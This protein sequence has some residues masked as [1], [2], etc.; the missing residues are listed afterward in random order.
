MT[1]SE[2]KE[3]Q[4]EFLNRWTIENVK[5]L[6][7]HEYVG[8]GNKDTFCQWVE[9]KTKM[10]GSI[11]GLTSIKFGIYERKDPFKRPKNYKNDDQYSWVQSYGDNRESAFGSTKRDILKI[12]QFSECGKF[13][14]IDNIPLLDLFKWKVAF[15]YSNERLIPIY[16]R[17][18][19]YKIANHFGLVTNRHIKISEIQN[20]MMQ[21]KPTHLSVYAYMWELYEKFGNNKDRK[22]VI[23]TQKLQRR[24]IRKA[25][26]GRNITPQTRT[27]TRSYIADQ[28]HN[29][30]QEALVLLLSQKY[31]RENV[32]LEENYVD[33]KLI[34]PN[35]IAFYEVKTSSYAS[36]CIKEA[37]GQILLYSSNDTDKRSKKH[38]IVGQ[39]PITEND[40]KFID[41]L[42]Q[43]INL[44]IDY[45]SVEIE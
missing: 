22:E 21:N 19:L 1:I 43:N 16:K 25:S 38:I 40:K 10:L 35:F 26:N 41:F 45:L 31:G 39:Y 23:E 34:Q 13:S 24:I 9:T 7:L 20:V 3:L 30:I 36:G 6:T 29:K 5:N 44:E 12:I 33:I 27:I 15:L 8:L 28:K 2:L 42:K 37:L 11:K 18:V 17:D 32:I 4:D 14:E